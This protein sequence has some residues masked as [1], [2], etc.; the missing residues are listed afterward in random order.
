M[1]F[2]PHFLFYRYFVTL[3]PPI[4][5]PTGKLSPQFFSLPVWNTYR[6][7]L[8][9][10]AILFYF[11][12]SHVFRFFFRCFIRRV[13]LWLSV[14]HPG[15]N[16]TLATHDPKRH[17]VYYLF[18]MMFF[19]PYFIFYRFLSSTTTRRACNLQVN[20]SPVFFFFFLALWNTFRLIL[21]LKAISCIPMAEP[22]SPWMKLNPGVVS[23]SFINGAK[24]RYSNDNGPV[25]VLPPN[26]SSSATYAAA[27]FFIFF[28]DNHR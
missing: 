27:L 16:P 22:Y 20:G 6:F 1:F 5:Q 21:T 14:I 28:Y 9:L 17:L 23:S 8:I 4:L 12:Y 19:F 11:S 7:V 10:N 24:Q 13:F 15:W 26:P 2:F 18:R 25:S 3:R